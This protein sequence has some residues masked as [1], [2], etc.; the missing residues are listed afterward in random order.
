MET[1]WKS[2]NSLQ[3][4]VL[5]CKQQ[6][7]FPTV[8][9]GKGF[10]KRIYSGECLRPQTGLVQRAHLCTTACTSNPTSTK[11]WSSPPTP[12]PCAAQGDAIVLKL[13][14]LPDRQCV[15]TQPE[16]QGSSLLPRIKAFISFLRAL[17]S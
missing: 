6:K 1:T 12:L 11:C 13:L 3:L 17:P 14:P 7:P 15:L 2:K 16:E 10:I 5:H 4:R 9:D 8:L